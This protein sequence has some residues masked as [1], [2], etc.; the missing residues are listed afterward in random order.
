[1]DFPGSPKILSRLGSIC[2]SEFLSFERRQY[3][4]SRI[5]GFRK[6]EKSIP[7]HLDYLKISYDTIR[8]D[9]YEYYF[10]ERLRRTQDFNPAVYPLD[11]WSK[12]LRKRRYQNPPSDSTVLALVSPY[13]DYVQT[14][15]EKLVFDLLGNRTTIYLK[16]LEFCD[17]RIYRIPVEMK[18]QAETIET[19]YLSLRYADLDQLSNVLGP[20]P[21]KEFSTE[22]RRFDNFTHHIVRNSEKLVLTFGTEDFDPQRINHMNVHLRGFLRYSLIRYMN[23]WIENGPEV[24]M[25]FTGDIK[26]SEYEPPRGFDNE[27][28]LIMKMMNLKKSESG[29]KGVKPDKRFPNTVYSIS[30]PRTN[31]PDSEI[32][33]SFIK[34]ASTDSPFQIHLKVQASGTAIPEKS[35]SMCLGWKFE[36]IVM[37]FMFFIGSFLFV[38]IFSQLILEYSNN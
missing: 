19:E 14:P 9:E 22:L 2:V 20:K 29:G 4:A 38:I 27:K 15:F 31:N 11:V 34:N 17:D 12:E 26:K 25:E 37:F 24:G 33:M 8:I 35:D 6:V 18:I 21:L 36:N 32:Q 16:K 10:T 30:M 23:A 1:M 5:P 28:T 3:I 7:L 13:Q